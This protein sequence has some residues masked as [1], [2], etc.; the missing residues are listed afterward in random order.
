MERVRKNKRKTLTR[1][2]DGSENERTNIIG[3]NLI[4]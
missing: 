4:A 1:G 3:D 2:N